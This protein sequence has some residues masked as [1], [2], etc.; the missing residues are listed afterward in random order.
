[1]PVVLPKRYVHNPSPLKNMPHD[2]VGTQTKPRDH[3]AGTSPTRHHQSAA[4][5]AATTTSTTSVR[6]TSTPIAPE[7]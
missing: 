4:A 6:C 3:T 5:N 1:M 2:L 7:Q